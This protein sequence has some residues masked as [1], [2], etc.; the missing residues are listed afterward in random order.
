MRNKSH[1]NFRHHKPIQPKALQQVQ[2]ITDKSINE[3]ERGLSLKDFK[4]IEQYLL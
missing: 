2:N 4:I 3:D 1:G